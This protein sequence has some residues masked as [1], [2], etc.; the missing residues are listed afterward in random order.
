MTN[1]N[2]TRLPGRATSD[3]L[4]PGSEDGSA[5]ERREYN[6]TPWNGNLDEAEI[7]KPGGL[8][9]AA[10]IRHANERR[11]LLQEMAK[12]LGVTYGYINQLRNG[13]RNVSQV[14]DDFA[15]SCSRYLGVPRMT[16]L[17]LSGRVTVGDV[18][19]SQQAM[20]SDISRAMHFICD[21]PHW[22]HLITLELRKSS[23]ESQYA[24]VRLYEKAT[25]KVLMDNH[26]NVETL[27]V[28]VSKLHDY[29]KSLQTGL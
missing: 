5:T 10:L 19:E 8:L 6:R 28:E 21:D 18:F 11:Q 23:V 9:I 25:G 29:R 26:L 24:L 4:E 16:V 20:L 17:M 13:L 7:A 1:S 12:D 2:V 3:S 15:L 14:S 27:A 22:G